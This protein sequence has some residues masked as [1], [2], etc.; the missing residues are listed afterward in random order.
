MSRVAEFEIGRVDPPRETVI[1]SG[2]IGNSSLLVAGDRGAGLT[3]VGEA[4]VLAAG[5]AVA[6]AQVGLRLF[7]REFCSHG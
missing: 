7:V 2:V 6:L 4:K 3:S 1:G 5:K